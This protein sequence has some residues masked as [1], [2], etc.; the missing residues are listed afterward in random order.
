MCNKEK[1]KVS[2]QLTE[3]EIEKVN[4]IPTLVELCK[5]AVE[6]QDSGLNKDYCFDVLESFIPVLKRHCPILKVVNN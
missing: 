6:I 5:L 4:K 1:K 2:K 3:K